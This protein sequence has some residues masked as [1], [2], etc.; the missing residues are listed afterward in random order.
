MPW[1]QHTGNG[2]PDQRRN[3][4]NRCVQI[5]YAGVGEAG[6]RLDPDYEKRTQKEELGSEEKVSGLKAEKKK[7][8]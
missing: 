6:L 7:E 8:M 1:T 4:W 5:R 2:E 3:A